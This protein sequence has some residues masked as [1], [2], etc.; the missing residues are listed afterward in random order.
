MMRF[1]SMAAPV[2]ALLASAGAVAETLKVEVTR[3]HLLTPPAPA[4]TG[5]AIAIAPAPAAAENES[6]PPDLQFG[7]L[8]AAASGA[9]TRAG[10]RPMAA[11]QSADYVARI[12]LTSSSEVVQKRPSLSIGLGASTGGW[13]GGIGG[14]VAFPVGG[15][16]RTVTAATMTLQIRRTSDNSAVW[17]GR[18]TTIAPSTDPMS[19]APALLEALLKGFP[20]PNGESVKLRVKAD[21]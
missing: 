4:I 18:A 20:G 10:F 5:A 14:G 6:P 12:A 1:L 9:L 21:P 2:A 8:A 15:G 16:T 13:N 3:F 11:G 7:A 19:A 17:E